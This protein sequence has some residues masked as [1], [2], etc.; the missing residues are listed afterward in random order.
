[1]KYAVEM[2]FINTWENCWKD[3]AGNPELFDSRDD[4]Q[5][6][7]KDHITDCINAVEGGDMEDSPDPSEFRVVAVGGPIE[8][9]DEYEIHGC[10]EITENGH[11]WTEQCE[12]SEAHFFT[13]YGHIPDGG[14]DTI[15]DFKTRE[16][17]EE[18]LLRIN[19]PAR[20]AASQL[21][22]ALEYFFNIMHDYQSSVRKGYVKHA[23]DQARAAIL[24][25]TGRATV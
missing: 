4:A 6:A 15:G 20:D 16:L 18:I 9:F 5:E 8:P 12:D 19:P 7:I 22:E 3:D 21:L 23:L 10:H 11:T 1:M 14:V 17:A 24:K 2:L 25:A 13:L